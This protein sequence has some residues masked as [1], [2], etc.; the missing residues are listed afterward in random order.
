MF[1]GVPGQ[2]IRTHQASHVCTPFSP[3]PSKFLNVE[4]WS[5]QRELRS[6]RMINGDPTQPN[7]NH[8]ECKTKKK[9]ISCISLKPQF[10]D[11]MLLRAFL[12]PTMRTADERYMW[13]C[14]ERTFALHQITH[15]PH[16]SSRS[17]FGLPTGALDTQ[18]S[19]DS[20]TSFVTP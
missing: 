13:L 9:N 17:R 19:S 7:M 12:S 10:G 15:T 14:S 18:I 16:R 20:K 8:F 4:D 6:E 2:E 11:H 3:M 5:G 1:A